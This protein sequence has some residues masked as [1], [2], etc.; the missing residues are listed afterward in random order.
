MRLVNL[1]ILFLF[2]FNFLFDGSL[3]I[4]ISVKKNQLISIFLFYFI[5][6]VPLS[7]TLSRSIVITT[8]CSNV[9]RPLPAL[10]SL[11]LSLFPFFSLFSLSSHLSLSPF[12]FF[13]Y[14]PIPLVISKIH[15]YFYFNFNFETSSILPS[16]PS[17]STSFSPS[18][19]AI[20]TEGFST[21]D[22]YYRVVA[23]ERELSIEKGK[24][25]EATLYLVNAAA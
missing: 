2:C 23:T 18:S 10:F 12:L 11:L 9:F 3:E 16:G 25:I 21:I 19:S 14:L 7:L 8:I 24:R 15:Y 5:L 6:F 13:Q 4:L 17:D 1:S 20:L 22:M